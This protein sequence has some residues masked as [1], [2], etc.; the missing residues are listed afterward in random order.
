MKKVYL[1]NAATTKVDPEVFRAMEPFLKD[2]FGNPSSVHFWGRTSKEAIE[3]VRQLVAQ[4]LGAQDGREIIF[5]GSATEANNLALKGVVE[6]RAK[7]TKT[8]VHLLV[9]SIEHHA[10]LDCAKHLKELGQEVTF[11]PVDQNGLV[12]PEEVAKAIKENTVLVSV[13]SVNNEIGTIEPIPEIGKIL[14]Q[15]NRERAKNGLERVFFHTDAV[16]AIQYLPSQVDYL[17]VDLL[18]LTAH[19]FYGPKG[20]GVLYR[21]RGTPLRR[22]MD[23]GEQEF[24]LR[25]GTENVSGIVGLGKALELVQKEQKE[26]RGEKIARLRDRLI[27]QVLQKVLGV[28]LTGHPQKRAPHIASFVVEGVEGEAVLLHLDGQGVA[29]S[30]GSAC[31]SGLLEPSHVLLSMGIPPEMAHG[32]LRFSLG[33]ETTAQEIDYLV[34][35]LPPI[36]GK[37]RQMAPDLTGVVFEKEE[38][39]HHLG[40]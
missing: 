8:P 4:F 12:D 25:A 20:V 15:V 3:K 18:S 23:G 38:E 33:K 9:S 34:K 7:E 24:G 1:D 31:T 6:A 5:T 36:V 22:Q 13:M 2:S 27:S 19:K 32:S 40:V 26:K 11:L 14:A 21:R 16:Q 28:K 37:L 30:S 39:P 35:I 17:G 29:A 10:V